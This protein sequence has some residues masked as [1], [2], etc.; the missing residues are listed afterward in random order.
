MSEGDRFRHVQSILRRYQAVS[1][2]IAS[3]SEKEREFVFCETLDEAWAKAKESGKRVEKYNVRRARE[4]AMRKMAD[5]LIGPQDP[6][7]GHAE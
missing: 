3:L 5:Y 2:A 4:R 7:N 1:A 6:D